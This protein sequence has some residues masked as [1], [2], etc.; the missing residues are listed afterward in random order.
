MHLIVFTKSKAVSAHIKKIIVQP[1][2]VFDDL[3]K[4]NSQ[5]DG[6]LVVLHVDSFEE[7]ALTVF[8]EVANK[9]QCLLALAQDV[10]SAQT[11]LSFT[12]RGVRAFF[13]SFMAAEHYKHMLQLLIE[14]QSWFAPNLLEDVFGLA[15]KQV[16][17][18]TIN[19]SIHDKLTAREQEIANSVANGSSNKDIAIQFSI[20]ER[21]V[22]AHLS[23]IF[24]KLGV[25][26]RVALAILL[27][28]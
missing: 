4:I 1:V 8:F 11:M 18:D 3:K 15:R 7:H 5:M 28:K 6:S 9:K 22:K 23:S 13:N 12:N 14:G 26:D 27:S 20:T 17:V 21:T 10:P 24:E 19:T 16:E 2:T 25:K